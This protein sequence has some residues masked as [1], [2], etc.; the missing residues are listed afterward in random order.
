MSRSSR[1]PGA[2]RRQ[3]AAREALA[4]VEE[5]RSRL[6][7]HRADVLAD[8]VEA[9]GGEVDRDAILEGAG[10]CGMGQQAMATEL[11]NA[12]RLRQCFPSALLLLREGRMRVRTVEILLEL[13]KDCTD[14]VQREVGHRLIG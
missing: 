9:H 13:T 14:R 6:F 12:M 11:H 10:T 7:A 8:L 5:D 4:G 1:E 3:R 2:L